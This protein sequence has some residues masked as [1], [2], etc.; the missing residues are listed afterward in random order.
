MPRLI[1]FRVGAYQGHGPVHVIVEH[2][3]LV[4]ELLV[5]SMSQY[6]LL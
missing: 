6:F 4:R 5:V 1:F 3:F 2:C